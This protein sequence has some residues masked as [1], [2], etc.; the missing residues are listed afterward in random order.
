[1]SLSWLIHEF[2]IDAENVFLDYNKGFILMNTV[3]SKNLYFR[4]K[5]YFFGQPHYK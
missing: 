4:I 5:D 1:M 2:F 3:K